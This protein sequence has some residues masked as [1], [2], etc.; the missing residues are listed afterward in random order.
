MPRK[1]NMH[2]TKR[3]G[4]SVPAA[5][6]ENGQNAQPAEK[7]VE[8]SQEQQR[9][10]DI[11]H[12]R[13][14]EIFIQDCSS[15][16]VQSPI[17]ISHCG[18][19]M[20]AAIISKG[21]S[22]DQIIYHI[23]KHCD[24]AHRKEAGIAGQQ[25]LVLLTSK[26][27]TNGNFEYIATISRKFGEA[28]LRE[29]NYFLGR[30]LYERAR[31]LGALTDDLSSTNSTIKFYLHEYKIGITH[32]VFEDVCSW[33]GHEIGGH[34]VIR[35]SE[36]LSRFGLNSQK[37]SSDKALDEF[38]T[39]LNSVGIGVAPH[40]NLVR[41][42][43]NSEVI[44][45]RTSSQ[46]TPLPNHFHELVNGLIATVLATSI[47]HKANCLT[48]NKKS[49]IFEIIL[50]VFNLS[51]H[52]KC[53]ILG[54]LAWFFLN[55]PTNLILLSAL[56]STSVE[57]A[58]RLRRIA[59]AC[60]GEVRAVDRKLVSHLEE[61]YGV[62]WLPPALAYSDLH[63]GEVADG[64]RTVRA[65]Q[66]GRPGEAIPELGKASGPKL[67]ASRIAAI[68]SDT[69]RV[70]SVLGQIFD[71]EEEESGASGP[72]SQSQLAGL[73]PKHGALVLELVNREH[74]SETEFEKICA[75]HGLMA[76]GALEVVNEWAFETYDEALL[77]EYDGYDVSPEIA[78][79]VKEKMSAEGRDV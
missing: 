22:G 62:L 26:R 63:A 34:K 61:I 8:I 43:I 9:T 75:S 20:F 16:E 46:I 41:R 31:N 39:K 30:F 73:D 69:E 27:L 68:R 49:R 40:L 29:R 25:G 33:I 44:A 70:S 42:K 17:D 54:N 2:V 10:Q 64:P 53:H 37:A 48:E 24:G 4:V 13:A 19:G 58:Q 32:Q 7:P 14:L 3:L 23:G 38:E 79:A 1:I 71:V 15:K 51:E 72:G 45:F 67:D 18:L 6:W 5:P 74:W 55:P 56:R 28:P 12:E 47:L 50:E 21:V 77:D 35:F 66:P 59:V 36:L 52:E 57:H 11:R 65:S 76:S 60:A 78:E